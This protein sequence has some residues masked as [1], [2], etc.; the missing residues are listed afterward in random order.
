[1][2]VV[3]GAQNRAREATVPAHAG[4]AVGGA[5][6]QAAHAKQAKELQ[7]GQEALAAERA[8]LA[9]EREEIKA[10]RAEVTALVCACV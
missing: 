1:M 8:Q 7:A 5:H 10:K 9:A 4:F 6:T 3:A 2:W